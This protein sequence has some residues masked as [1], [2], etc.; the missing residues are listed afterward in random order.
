MSAYLEPKLVPICLGETMQLSDLGRK[1]FVKFYLEI[2]DIYI[3][4]SLVLIASTS[5][6]QSLQQYM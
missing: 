4:Y 1:L 6:T 5:I 2:V 3:D